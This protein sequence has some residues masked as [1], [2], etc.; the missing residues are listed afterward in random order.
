MESASLSLRHGFGM[1]VIDPIRQSA[2]AASDTE[3]G[4][5]AD[6]G[7]SPL[8]RLRTPVWIYDIDHGRIVWANP[9]A[10][11]LWCS[12]DLEE[13]RRRDMAR[14]M[15]PAIA[16]RLLQLQH[17]FHLH[18]RSCTELWTLYPRGMPRTVDIV[19]SGWPLEDGR[20]GMLCEAVGETMTDAVT[21]RSAEAMVHTP[22]MVTLYS[23]RGRALYRNPAARA[24]VDHPDAGAR[25][26]MIDRRE[27][28]QLVERLHRS[29]QARAT[30]QVNTSLGP[31]WHDI[32]VRLCRDPVEG[33]QV[34]L[35][36][37]IDITELKQAEARAHW[38]AMRDTLTG[39]PNRSFVSR[40]FQQRLD[41]LHASGGE[42]ALIFIDLDRFKAVND[43]L[44]HDIGDRLLVEIAQRLYA[45][46]ETDDLVA[47]LGGDEFLV[48]VANRDG[49]IER[50][51]RQLVRRLQAELGRTVMIGRLQMQV[52]PSMG[53]CRFPRDGHD[54]EA[55]LRNAD[56]ALYRAK[57]GGRNGVGW[58]TPELVRIARDRVQL[59]Q[60]LRIAVERHQFEVFYQPRLHVGSGRLLGAE[61]LVRWRHPRRG[62][63]PPD[64]FIG[65]SEDTGLI[66]AIGAMVLEQAARQQVLWQSQG[67]RLRISVNLSPRQFGDPALLD[68]IERIVRD[69]GCDPQQLELE[70]T[71]SVMLGQDES[72]AQAIQKLALMG[73]RLAID[74]FGTGYSNLAYLQR[75]PISTLKIDRSFIAGEHGVSPLARL[76]ITMCRMLGIETVAEGVETEAQL[77][78]LR[79][80]DCDEYQGHLCSPALPADQ[81]ERRMLEPVRPA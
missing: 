40:D 61:A 68:T 53:I 17:D 72:T 58:F 35:V 7:L 24:T 71:E 33:R 16:Q 11:G 4:L 15:S 9:A 76:V 29:G 75:C 8:Q 47:R 44:G 65:L 22:V 59:E 41:G 77:D 43:S 30:A 32:S 70:I 48:L 27:L 31:R 78:W 42:A 28:R 23:V 46:L 5:C 50:R 62:L 19:C 67:H 13:L 1:A 52:T 74:D 6:T 18:D 63:V 12:D 38:L 80:Q 26:R 21:L 2:N 20:M 49:D 64:V 79:A 51:T 25:S 3:D 34:F 73:F 55:L 54:I 69:T 37:E 45:T 56:L 57:Q 10:L 60:D 36:S 39:L 14:E 81:F 66:R